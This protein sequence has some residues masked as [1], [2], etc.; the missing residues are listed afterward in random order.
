MVTAND[1]HRRPHG[2]QKITL[3]RWAANRHGRGDALPTLE[4]RHEPEPVLK[5]VEEDL[6]PR[7][8]EERVSTS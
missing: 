6:I 5:D 1:S 2:H 3:I 8:Q 4:D 7:N